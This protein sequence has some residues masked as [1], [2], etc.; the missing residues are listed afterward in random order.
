MSQ[1]WESGKLSHPRIISFF[2][3]KCQI[4][5][6]FKRFLESNCFYFRSIFDV[7]LKALMVAFSVD[8]F[9]NGGFCFRPRA[10][11]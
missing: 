1:K 8:K 6:I 10:L 4:V 7:L 11:K 3:Y 9:P 5:P 2:I